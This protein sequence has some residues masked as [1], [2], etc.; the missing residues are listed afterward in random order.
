MFVSVVD[1]SSGTQCCI[2]LSVLLQTN[3]SDQGL[4]ARF[5]IIIIIIIITLFLTLGIFTPEGIKN[6]NNNNNP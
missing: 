1:F 3:V 2:L 4:T 6:N 5:S